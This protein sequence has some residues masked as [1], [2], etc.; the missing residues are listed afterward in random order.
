MSDEPEQVE[1]K[2]MRLLPPKKGVCQ[3]CA[4][5]H[6]AIL[7]HDFTTLYYQMQF[8]GR[9][10]R[11]ATWADAAAHCDKAMLHKWR[12]VM[13]QKGVKWTEPPEGIDPIV[14][15]YRDG[16]LPPGKDG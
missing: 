3:I 2:S 13:R 8:K 4:R 14:Q 7:P 5:A 9:F 6:E 15:E 16:S 10:G 11:D 1:H 12:A